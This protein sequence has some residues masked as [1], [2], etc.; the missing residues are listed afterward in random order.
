MNENWEPPK[1][2]NSKLT[3]YNYIVQYP[4]NLTLGENFDIGSFTYINSKHGVEIQDLVQIGSHCSIYSHS[5][6]DSKQGPVKLMENCRIGTHSTVMPNVTI[7]ENSIIAGQVGIAG[8]ST[9]GNNVKIGGQ[10]GISGHLKIGNNVEIGGG[11]TKNATGYLVVIDPDG[12]ADL[13][14]H[15]RFFSLLSLDEIDIYPGSIIYAPKDIGGLSGI[16]Y[17]STVAPIVS[18]LALSLA[19]LYSISDN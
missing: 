12:K 9:I 18:S 4:E 8:S 3:K 19:S 5:T 16:Q 11:L 10:A 2:E 15:R 1:I 14:D 7:G 17:A 6:I 13:Y